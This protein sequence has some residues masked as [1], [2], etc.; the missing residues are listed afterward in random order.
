MVHGKSKK[1]FTLVELLVVITILAILM[2]IGIA[3]YSGVQKNARDLRRKSDLR[4]IK[5]AL[6]LFYQANGKYPVVP[7]WVN[8]TAT[9]PWIP[10]LTTD[11]VSQLPKDP[12]N[13]GTTTPWTTASSYVYA[14]FSIPA[15]GYASCPNYPEG[16][17]FLLVAQLENKSDG[18]NVLHKDNKWCDGAG[19]KTTHGWSDSA[20]VITS[21]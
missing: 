1:G 5:I 6:E 2:T 20:Y 7:T 14:Y 8:S 16:Q 18:E 9:Q 10:G 21:L 4:S 3:V 11:Y 13:S 19:L 15:G 12:F 17:F